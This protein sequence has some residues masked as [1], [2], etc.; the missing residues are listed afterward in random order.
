M[1]Y[2]GDD[3]FLA[4][5]VPFVAEGVRVGQPVM[6][7]VPQPR[8]E[9]LTSAL[10]RH[11]DDV[12]LADMGELGR[13]P[14]RI[15]PAWQDFVDEYGGSG[16]PVRGVGEPVWSGRRR[17]ELRE[18]QLHES[19]LNVAVGADTALWLRCPY[20]LDTLEPAVVA[21]AHR[22]HPVVVGPHGPPVGPAYR[23]MRRPAFCS[24]NR[25]PSRRSAPPSW[26]SARQRSMDCA[27][28]SPA[29]P[30]RPASCGAG[31]TTACSR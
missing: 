22:S 1:L 31:A 4:Q 18:C 16:R 2:H 10:G 17:A 3:D 25:C 23:G 13:N 26:P 20:D 8:L 12:V 5:I 7:A 6:V 30:K 9:A 24:A 11:A 15:I 28:R 14:A 19:L 27:R 21:Q 29:W